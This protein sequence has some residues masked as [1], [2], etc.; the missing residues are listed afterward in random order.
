MHNTCL[1]ERRIRDAEG[2]PGSTPAE[3]ILIDGRNAI[4]HAGVPINIRDID[5]VHYAHTVVHVSATSVTAVIPR[6]PP[7]IEGLPRSQG[8]PTDV[9][10]A[11]SDT[12]GAESKE[13][14]QRRA[15]VM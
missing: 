14:N 8:N 5:V 1:P 2:I 9:A 3:A 10:E 4:S 13:S 12:N 6:A 7:R 15:P 11:E